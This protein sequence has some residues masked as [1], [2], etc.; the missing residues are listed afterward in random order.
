MRPRCSHWPMRGQPGRPGAHPHATVPALPP[1]A[2]QDGFTRRAWLQAA[3]GAWGGMGL[4]GAALAADCASAAPGLPT[5][6]G[7]SG[8]GAN[9][10]R[11][12]PLEFPRDHGAHP[13]SRIEW[14]YATGWLARTAQDLLGFQLTF[15]RS[16]TGL[17]GDLSGRLAPRQLLFAHAAITEVRQGHHRHAQRVARWSGQPSAAGP[18]ASSADTELRLGAWHLSRSPASG[19]YRARLPAPEAGFTL[20]IELQPTQPLLLQGDAGWSAKGPPLPSAHAGPATTVHASHYYSL[21]HLQAEARVAVGQRT[22]TLSGQAWLD[23][24]WSD[25]LM[26]P[27]AVGWDWI[28]INLTD[29]GALTAFVLRDRAGQPV[30]A[31]GSHRRRDGPV[32]P[33]EPG[34]VRFTALREWVSPATGGRYPVH[35]RIETPAGRHDL[36]ALLDA[37]E[38]DSRS[39]TGTLYWEGLA[40]LRHEAGGRAGLGY[41]EMTGRAQPLRLP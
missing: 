6:T 13:D 8:A 9:V 31:G 33:F 26:S 11:G 12:R 24:E 25:A 37:Q 39:S 17:G 10:C 2:G 27:A 23:H 3:C 32:V 5:L 28:G 38:L 21:P 19:R 14:W 16:R 1:V 20:E 22:E 34:Q 7:E 18:W 30:W 40:E 15:F 29:G 36:V 4:P 41:L 35:W